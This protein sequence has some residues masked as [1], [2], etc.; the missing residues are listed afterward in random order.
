MCAA[1]LSKNDRAFGTI[2][3]Q[4]AVEAEK[5]SD[6]QRLNKITVLS[7]TKLT[8]KTCKE[9]VAVVHFGV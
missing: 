7:A 1:L 2:V 5:T 8:I 6:V 9:T 3:K 4:A